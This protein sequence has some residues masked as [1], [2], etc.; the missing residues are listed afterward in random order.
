M[1][2]FGSVDEILNYA[3]EKEKE[4]A[5][6]YTDLAGR[7]KSAST[8]KVLQDLAEE[9]QGHQAK[10][11][12]I[13]EGRLSLRPGVAVTD[14]KISDYLVDVSPKP[15]MDDQQALILAMKREKESFR[16]YSDLA[17]NVEKAELRQALT[18]LAL[19]E[20]RHKLRLEIEYDEHYLTDN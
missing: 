19:E 6:F 3:I 7:V 13:R 11:K 12:A 18:S 5:A 20:A 2:K 10:L 17:Q 16:L 4:A 15:D 8:V 14:L 1:P 9:E